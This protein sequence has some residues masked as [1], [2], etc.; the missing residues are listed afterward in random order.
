MLGERAMTRASTAIVC[1]RSSSATLRTYTQG[2]NGMVDLSVKIGSLTLANPV[3]PGSG[4]FAETMAS[5]I[6]LD[7]LG[8]IV[9]K[10]IRRTFAPVIRSR[11]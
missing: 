6:D 9:T 8:A 5:V 10:T 1:H 7:R 4:T 3:M 11:G 2:D